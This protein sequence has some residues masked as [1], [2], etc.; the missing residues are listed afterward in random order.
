[1]TQVYLNTISGELSETPGG[2]PILR[3][4]GKRGTNFDL[5]VIPDADI[6]LAS[7]GFFSAKSAYTGALVAHG[8]WTAPAAL[9]G[10]FT[11][12]VSLRGTDLS[13]LF[14]AGL[15]SVPLM[16]ELT[17]VIN[18]K[19]RKSQTITLTVARNVYIG[20]ETEPEDLENTRRTV[21]GYQEYSFD[22]GTTWR[23]YAPVLVD[24][25]PEWRWS[26]PFTD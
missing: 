16:A 22:G 1:M 5:E 9:G 12:S 10:S 4:T 25:V 20:D 6:P 26:D 13:T 7:A 2:P 17:A 23:R 24:G 14:T 3:M 19:T 11:F 21:D 8:T 15:G 18:S